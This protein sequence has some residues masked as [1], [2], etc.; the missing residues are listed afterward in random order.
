MRVIAMR[1]GIDGEKTRQ[2]LSNP[3]HPRPM[4]IST[5][6]IRPESPVGLGVTRLPWGISCAAYPKSLS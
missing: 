2:A 6:I 4:S 1:L 5:E 3:V